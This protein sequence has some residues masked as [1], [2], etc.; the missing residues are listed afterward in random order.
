MTTPLK[1]FYEKTTNSTFANFQEKFEFRELRVVPK[2]LYVVKY[3]KFWHIS[4]DDW[5]YPEIIN[6]HSMNVLSNMFPA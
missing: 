4:L 5:Y 1:S 3:M 2:Q 6:N